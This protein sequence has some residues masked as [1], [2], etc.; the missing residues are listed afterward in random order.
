MPQKV[1]DHF[2]HTHQLVV[3]FDGAE[4]DERCFACKNLF[5]GFAYHCSVCKFYLHESCADL[6]LP[7]KIQHFYH[8]SHP[9]TLHAIG[10][11]E[12]VI[13]DV[14]KERLMGF[15]YCCNDCDFNVDVLCAKLQP[16]IQLS[17]HP[18]RPLRLSQI[19]DTVTENDT[20]FFCDFCNN[21]CYSDRGQT[22]CCKICN[23][24]SILT[25][26]ECFLTLSTFNMSPTSIG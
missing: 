19:G 8:S 3:G 21:R 22:F 12:T 5:E 14:C 24:R 23:F 1:I 16:E 18:D 13:C 20:Y 17:I 2:N 4:R 11:D 26:L 9:L 7:A 25:A 15:T 10:N 6:A